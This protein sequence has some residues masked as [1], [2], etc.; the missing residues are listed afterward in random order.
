MTQTYSQSQEDHIRKQLNALRDE[1]TTK[2]EGLLL[3][4]YYDDLVAADAAL[5]QTIPYFAPPHDRPVVT[6]DGD[7]EFGAIPYWAKNPSQIPYA[8]KIPSILLEGLKLLDD[9]GVFPPPTI[10][11]SEYNTL[12]N[13]VQGGYA[14]GSDGTL[15]STE[16]YGQLNFRW[17][18]AVINVFFVNHI[19]KKSPFITT[20]STASLTGAN[21]DAIKIALIGDWGTGASDAQNVR[22]AAMALNPDYLIH[23]GDVYY[24]GTPQWSDLRPFVGMDDEVNHLVNQWPANMA[25]G[26]SY[27]MNSN[28]E[29]YCGAYGLYEDALTAAPFKHQQ[30]CTYF[31]L[32]NDNYQIFGL[33]SAYD[34]P[35]WLFMDGALNQSQINFVQS[36]IDSS[37]TTV[38]LTHHTPFNL[39]GTEKISKQKGGTTVSLWNQMIEATNK[40]VPDYWYFGHIHDGIAYVEPKGGNYFD[41]CKARCTGHASMPY[42]APWGLAKPNAV[43]PFKA[44]DWID[45]VEFAA[46]T[47]KDASKPN[48]QVKNGFML[49]T[50]SPNG[51]KESFY[52]EDGTETWSSS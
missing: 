27:T 28:H 5:K 6:S 2:T 23:L 37:K 46:G 44:G 1:L 48:G 38:I 35:D 16:P 33:D 36:K 25:N 40:K 15:W 26:Q 11:Q 49:I 45:T 29:M 9:A 52:D 42:G 12:L 13:A 4:T 10:T 31:L 34:S 39:T 3:S 22:D 43:A 21:T 51:I 14:V 32:E 30:G 41:G 47:P 18:E 17:I 7:V 8:D 24:T 20:P 19:Y 50:L